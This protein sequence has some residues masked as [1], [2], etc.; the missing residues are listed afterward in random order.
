MRLSDSDIVTICAREIEQAR[1]LQESI[2][3]HLRAKN[4]DLYN[5]TTGRHIPQ[6]EEGRSNVVSHDVS[7]T[8]H[9]LLPDIIAT[10]WSGKVQFPSLGE[11]DERPA[12]AETDYVRQVLERAGESGYYGYTYD[13]AFDATLHG[14]GYWAVEPTENARAQAFRVDG[15]SE[16]QTLERN[17]RRVLRQRGFEDIALDGA[18]HI[19]GRRVEQGLGVRSIAPENFLHS[20]DAGVF[21]LDQLRFCAER[22]LMRADEL[23]DA[24]LTEAEAESLPKWTYSNL[25]AISRLGEKY[26]NKPDQAAQPQHDLVETFVCY[27]LLSDGVTKPSQL[28][29]VH[30]AGQQPNYL[31]DGPEPVNRHPYIAGSILPQPHRVDGRGVG[32]TMADI[33]ESKTML[34]RELI[35][36][37]A[38]ANGS[39]IAYD[40]NTVSP[41][42]LSSGRINKLVPV[43]GIP[44]QG[45]TGLPTTDITAQMIPALRY[46]DDQRASRG[47]AAVDKLSEGDRAVMQSSAEGAIGIQRSRD[48]AAAFY[49]D[50]LAQT[51]LA[52]LFKKAHA[53]LRDQGGVVAVLDRGQWVPTRPANWPVRRYCRAI[54]SKNEFERRQQMQTLVMLQQMLR[55]IMANGGNNVIT[56]IEKVYN[57]L[58]DFI[59]VTQVGEIPDYLID[60]QSAESIEAQRQIAETSAQAAATTR[61][62]MQLQQ[63][64]QEMALELDKYKHDR[65]TEFRYWAEE[66]KARTD[67]DTERMSNATDL[68]EA[69]M[70]TGEAAT[71][72]QQ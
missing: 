10:L 15:I 41:V 69:E 12:Q 17:A 22:V 2:F 67:V 42:A 39:G 14:T 40:E 4:W 28:Y 51:F 72:T 43:D 53:T 55:D 54:P 47:G 31:I 24:G 6:A 50:N 18:D 70:K 68:A 36:S 27:L 30:V 48:K 25:E 64:M 58:S 16:N 37:A 44:A 1:L 56:N 8:V 26:Q 65:E 21:S 46:M 61:D 9:A 38:V 59:R 20:D 34:S 49:A 19:V 62:V 7:E 57:V 32:E 3:A 33:Q 45:I 60:P 29:R 5:A 71:V 52:A 23:V 35:D 63:A 11:G 66:L 13:G